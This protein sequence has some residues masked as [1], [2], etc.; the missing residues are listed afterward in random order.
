M[1]W[2]RER[3]MPT[4]RPLFVREVSAYFADRGCHVVSV[5]DPYGSILGCL[6]LSHYIFLSSSSSTGLS[7]PRLAPKN[8]KTL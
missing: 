3:T 4:E 1:A 2:V 7:G 6:D 5:T 8:H